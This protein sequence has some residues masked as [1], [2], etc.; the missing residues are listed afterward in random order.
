VDVVRDEF[1]AKS[2]VVLEESFRLVVGVLPYER[3][4]KEADQRRGM[5]RLVERPP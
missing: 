1:D 2:K 3:P 5:L 4:A